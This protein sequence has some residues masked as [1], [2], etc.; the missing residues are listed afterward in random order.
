MFIDVELFI[1]ILEFGG[2]ADGMMEKNPR[3][4]L[5]FKADQR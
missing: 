5:G 1:N 2:N 3:K 4:Q